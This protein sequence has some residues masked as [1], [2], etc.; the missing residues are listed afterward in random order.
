MSRFDEILDDVIGK[1]KVA[2]DVTAK[3]TTE[4]VEFGKLKYKAKQ[5]AWDIEKAY[6]KLGAL[7][8]EARKSDE[9]FDDAVM[10]AVEEL[11]V[12]NSR[13]DDLEDKLA[14]LRTDTVKEA[15]S[16]RPRPEPEEAPTEEPEEE[17]YNYSENE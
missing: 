6:A 11:D 2:A 3:A 8:Y 12:L 14:D 17:V 15:R 7:V 1:A 9:N 13:L 4:M 10:L 5:I 16:S